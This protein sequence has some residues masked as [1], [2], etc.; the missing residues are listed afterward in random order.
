M[1]GRKIS[2]NMICRHVY[3]YIAENGMTNFLFSQLQKF[4]LEVGTQATD[5]LLN[6]LSMDR[7]DSEITG[8]ALETLCNVMSNEP[9][10]DGKTLSFLIWLA[11]RCVIK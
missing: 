9:P 6:V 7:S 8:Y 5:I 10:E 1:A 4:R 3:K 2:I 11:D